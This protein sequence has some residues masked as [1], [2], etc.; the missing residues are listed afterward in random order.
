MQTIK[1]TCT[2]S[3][4][5]DDVSFPPTYQPL[6]ISTISLFISLSRQSPWPPPLQ[7][8]SNLLTL[9]ASNPYPNLLL[10]P[11]S[12]PPTPSPLIPINSSLLSH[13]TPSPS[14][15][16]PYSLLVI[17]INATEPSRTLTKPV[18]NG[19]SSW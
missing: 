4:A 2:K 19:A 10:S 13:S 9:H 1:S 17:L 14:S 11:P 3:V 18:W 6:F 12:L 8:F 7:T 5:C 16:S 15:T